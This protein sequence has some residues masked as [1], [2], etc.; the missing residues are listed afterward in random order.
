MKLMEQN[1]LVKFLLEE[2]QDAT[3]ADF[4]NLKYMIEAKEF[5][6]KLNRKITVKPMVH[7]VPQE[8]KY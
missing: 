2:N 6:A 8:D 1:K 7:K 3:I 4:I 5:V